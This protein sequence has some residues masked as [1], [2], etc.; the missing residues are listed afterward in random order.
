[1]QI[2]IF[3]TAI[4]K[5]IKLPNKHNQVKFEF[6][7]ETLSDHSINEDGHSCGINED[8]EK[9]ELLT[10]FIFVGLHREAN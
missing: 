9:E 6:Q 10:M 4:D 5:L 3:L 8:S 1:M 7:S 2:F